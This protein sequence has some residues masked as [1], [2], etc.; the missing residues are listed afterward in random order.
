MS[1]YSMDPEQIVKP[2]QSSRLG[3]K[4]ATNVDLWSYGKW[5]GGFLRRSIAWRQAEDDQTWAKFTPWL[6]ASA[7]LLPALRRSTMV[8]DQEIA[9]RLEVLM[10]DTLT[11][12]SIAKRSDDEAVQAARDSLGTPTS[13]AAARRRAALV[14]WH[15]SQ[16]KNQRVGFQ[17]QYYVADDP[18]GLL[19]WI[20]PRRQESQVLASLAG[21]EAAKNRSDEKGW[22]ME[23]HNIFQNGGVFESSRYGDRMRQ[24]PAMETM[25]FS[26][27]SGLGQLW[28][29]DWEYAQAKPGNPRPGNP[30]PGNPRPGDQTP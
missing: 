5:Q 8:T 29:R 25:S 14:T 12:P 22:R 27:Q 1:S 17:Y 4:A 7:T 15:H 10:I 18:Q 16:D 9:D 26:Q 20:S 28:G 6:K 13:R 19:P 3:D 24:M 23:L 21:I 2:L 11:D 30:R